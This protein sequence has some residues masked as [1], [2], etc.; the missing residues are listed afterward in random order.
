MLPAVRRVFEARTSKRTRQVS[1]G[2]FVGLLCGVLPACQRDQGIRVYKV[3]KQDSKSRGV[4]QAAQSQSSEQQM[5]G[6]IVHSGKSA[7]F[8]K[9]TGEPSKVEPTREEFREIVDSVEFKPTGPSWKLATG[10]TQQ[11]SQGITYAKLLKEDEGLTA[12]VT[13]FPFPE[14][15]DESQWREYVVAN[16][17]RWRNQLALAPQEWSEIEP[18]LEEVTELSRGPAKAYFVSLVGKGS[19]SMAGGPFSGG[20]FSGGGPVAAESASSPPP[21]EP[22]QSPLS[23]EVPDGWSEVPASS[24]R[25]ASFK[26]D[27][28]DGQTAEVAVSVASGEI[29]MIVGMWISQIP[30]EKTDGNV[31]EVIDAATEQEVN[32]AQAKVY[33]VDGSD[34]ESKQAI[35]VADVPWADGSSLYVKLKG[36]SALVEAERKNFMAFLKSLKW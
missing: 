13:E 23:Y 35:L 20:P 32:G 7:W 4:I 1:I 36:D 16:I 15:Q 5:L 14:M 29:D 31:K 6:A 3:A 17:N 10:W 21:A 28:P 25:L 34:A 26:L 8:F 9:L 12:T 18:E 24:M 2:I 19:G 30:M 27:G 33:W 22:V 11:L